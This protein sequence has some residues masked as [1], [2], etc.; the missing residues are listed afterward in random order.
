MAA[1]GKGVVRGGAVNPIDVHVGSRVRLRRRMLGLTQG[2][3][4]QLLG[5]SLP[6][7]QKYE[8]GINRIS[9]SR[10]FDI[11]QILDV[12]ITFLFDDIDPVRASAVPEGFAEQAQATAEAGP[13]RRQETRDLVATYYEISDTAIRRRLIQLANAFRG[14]RHVGSLAEG[15]STYWASGCQA[16][17][18]GMILKMAEQRPNPSRVR[19]G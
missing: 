7:V 10:M 2:K 17:G 11:V 12:P 6:Q 15:K 5:L 13:L 18:D 1:E 8:G 14:R 19:P 16:N 9:A 4:A 3:F